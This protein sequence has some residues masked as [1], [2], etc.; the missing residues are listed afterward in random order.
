MVSEDLGDRALLV[1]ALAFFLFVV[2][3]GIEEVE[4]RAIYVHAEGKGG[5]KSS[6]DQ[7]RGLLFEGGEANR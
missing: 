1:E 6:R 2:V 4:R 5:G 7:G 3:E